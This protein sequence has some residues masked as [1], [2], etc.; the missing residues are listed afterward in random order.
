MSPPDETSAKTEATERQSAG[1]AA[2][3]DDRREGQLR[4]AVKDVQR[5]QSTSAENLRGSDSKSNEQLRESAEELPRPSPQ[6][7]A[8]EDLQK[9][10]LRLT[11]E[12]NVLYDRLS[13][14]DS[15]AKRLE[16]QT[17]RRPSRAF[18]RY[19]V[20]ICIGVAATLA[21]QFYGEAT[22]RI[23]ATNALELGWSPESKQMIAG[24]VQQLGWTTPQADAESAA[25][26]PSA[27]EPPQVA[28]VVQTAPAAIA[29]T[30]APSIDP[31]QLQQM[32][33]SLATLGQAVERIAA[34]QDQ[35]AREITRLDSAVAELDAKIPEPRPQPPAAVAR[36][37]ARVPPQ[38]AQSLR[39]PIASSRAPKPPQQ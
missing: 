12:R 2:G 5:L 10:L 35:M 36:K 15:Q 21:W 18:G 38:S 19:L 20:G 4:A 8:E 39:P 13:A 24:W 25:V 33:Q 31:E 29:P 1:A 14:I 23:I 16:T 28:P 27:P 7:K 34:G 6:R 30:I 32:T 11:S 26:R 9:V 17:Q 22:K 37:P 3:S